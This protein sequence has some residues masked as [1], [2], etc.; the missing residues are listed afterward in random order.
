MLGQAVN[1]VE[2]V[3]RVGNVMGYAANLPALTAIAWYHDRIDRTGKTLDGLLDESYNFAMSDYL[4][5]LARG[6]D[7]PDAE[8]ARI[9]ERLAA[10]T[11]F[12]PLLSPITLPFPKGSR[13]NPRKD[14]G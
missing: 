13:R 9:A 8:R 2:T 11:A 6:R 4:T 5:A 1:I 12:A 10:L 7:L 3:Q 14:R